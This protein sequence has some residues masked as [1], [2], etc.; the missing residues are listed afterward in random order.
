MSHGIWLLRHSTANTEFL[1]LGE[2]PYDIRTSGLPGNGIGMLYSC[3]IW[4]AVWAAK[5][6]TFPLIHLRASF[7]EG[8]IEGFDVGML[9]NMSCLITPSN[10]F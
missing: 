9:I 7:C 3:L 4:G 5:Y 8:P 1:V 6:G 2:K 10:F